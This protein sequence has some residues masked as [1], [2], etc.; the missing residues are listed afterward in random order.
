MLLWVTE[1]TS[2]KQLRATE[3]GAEVRGI[4]LLDDNLY[5]I[6]KNSSQIEAMHPA[7][8][9][10]VRSIPVPGMTNPGS[11]AGSA[12]QKSLFITCFMQKELLKVPVTGM[13][14]KGYV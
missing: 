13:P 5:V 12:S 1:V 11:M 7:T 6:R 10:P 14:G 4:A 9:T 3:P 2:Y 8:L